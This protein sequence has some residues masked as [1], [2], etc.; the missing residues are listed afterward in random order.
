[1]KELNTNVRAYADA[2]KS[3]LTENDGKYEVPKETIEEL[4]K[5]VELD[6]ATVKRAD[7][8]TT[9]FSAGLGCALGEVAVEK[10]KKDKALHEAYAE[11]RLGGK[12]LRS[13]FQREAML[14][15]GFGGEGK[16]A[17]KG[18]LVSRIVTKTNSKIFTEVK[19]H[20]NALAKSI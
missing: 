17:K 8:F 15:K 12:T 10:M 4:L 14:P 5:T 3:T 11:V 20:L 16:V 9:E 7:K 6:T 2:I 19:E 13:T 1:M 18:V